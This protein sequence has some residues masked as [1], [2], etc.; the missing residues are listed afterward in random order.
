MY[1]CYLSSLIQKQKL[2]LS[3]KFML[4]NKKYISL[5]LFYY[6][7]DF[8]IIKIIIVMMRMNLFIILSMYKNNVNNI[9]FCFM[10]WST[11]NLIL[12]LRCL[13]WS[14]KLFL[15]IRKREINVFKSK[16]TNYFWKFLN[17]LHALWNFIKKTYTFIYVVINTQ[18]NEKLKKLNKILNKLT[19]YAN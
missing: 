4:F 7:R 8:W 2:I 9:L 3:I 5:I 1:V 11:Q 19:N 18:K 10:Q 17:N 12:F 14:I 6:Y 13:Y 16:L 15:W